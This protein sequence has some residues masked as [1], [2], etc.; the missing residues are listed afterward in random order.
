MPGM[1]AYGWVAGICQPWGQ[2]SVWGLDGHSGS[3]WV[4]QASFFQLSEAV[5]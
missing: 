3:G 2:Y 1:G 4:S 5:G